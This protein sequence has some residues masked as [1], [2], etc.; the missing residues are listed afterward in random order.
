MDFL[1]FF[2]VV[3]PIFAPRRFC[4][5]L[6]C[7]I[8]S[9]HCGLLFF[10]IIPYLTLTPALGYSGFKVRIRIPRKLRG[11]YTRALRVK[12]I[13]ER[14]ESFGR[15]CHDQFHFDALPSGGRNSMLWKV[16]VVCYSPFFCSVDWL[17]HKCGR[18][19]FDFLAF[20]IYWVVDISKFLWQKA[21]NWFA[22]VAR[23]NTHEGS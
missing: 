14:A 18:V 20:G 11:I 12:I 1:C 4:S 13:N 6:R 2:F 5:W 21:T 10:F 9:W 23:Y 8:I 19:I 17:G 16:M 15:K 22:R 7:S 3:S